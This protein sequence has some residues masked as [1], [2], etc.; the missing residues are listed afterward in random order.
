M[1]IGKDEPGLQGSR[2]IQGTQG[3]GTVATEHEGRTHRRSA[4]S[5]AVS[6]ELKVAEITAVHSAVAF[7]W[8]ALL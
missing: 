3:R 7:V 1:L 6:I 5:G 4:T 2:A 8:L